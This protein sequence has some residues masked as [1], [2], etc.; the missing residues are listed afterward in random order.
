MATSGEKNEKRGVFD[1]K[2]IERSLKDFIFGRHIVNL[3]PKIYVRR[4]WFAA[5]AFVLVVVLA[6]F[7][8]GKFFTRAEVADFYPSVCLGT[9]RNVQ[10]AQGELETFGAAAQTEFTEDNSAVFAENP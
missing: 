10:N 3:R 9:W 2:K 1:V 4:P 5:A 8:A 7:G 6:V